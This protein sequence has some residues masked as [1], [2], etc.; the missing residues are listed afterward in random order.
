M[1]RCLLSLAVAVLPLAAGLRVCA[2]LD[3]SFDMLM[4]DKGSTDA[5]TVTSDSDLVGFNVDLRREILTNRLNLTYTLS[6]LSSYG[7]IMVETRRGNCDIGWAA[8]FNLG[9]R[10]R[11]VEDFATCRAL[12]ALPAT[13]APPSWT[14]W[15]CCVDFSPSIVNYG[16]AILYDPQRTSF[17]SALFSALSSVFFINFLCFLFVMIVIVAHLVWLFE[18]GYNDD[19][20]AYYLDGIDDA[21]WWTVVTI[22]TVGYGDKVPKTA[23]GR[24]VGILWLFIGLFLYSILTGHMADAF[25]EIRNE[26]RTFASVNELSGAGLRVASYEA[27]FA[28]DQIL[29][30][31][32]KGNRVFCATMSECEQKFERGE[33]DTMVMDSF[34][35]KYVRQKSTSWGNL[36]IS[37]DLNEYSIAIVYPEGVRTYADLVNPEITD[38]RQ[39][40]RHAEMTAQWAP[41]ASFA[42]GED[43]EPYQ[44]ELI[45]IALGMLGLYIILQIL[46]AVYSYR[47]RKG[48]AKATEVD[49]KMN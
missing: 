9:S 29:A 34:I 15:R 6:I 26:R 13:G 37:P 12:S 31:V 8:L 42:A 49:V 24:L 3:Q 21:V 4:G 7:E 35:L 44:W 1:P 25:A 43:D 40:A 5:S 18:R 39:S 20:P 19:F 10:E 47:K 46:N 27:L 38:F 30:P 23:G 17:F 36:I 14:P 33:T 32:A 2:V 48:E 16:V 41:Q 45:G 22:T 28:P 11:C